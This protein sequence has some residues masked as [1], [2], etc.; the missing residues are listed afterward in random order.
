MTL[1]LDLPV[2]T[3]ERLKQRARERGQDV[4]QYVRDLVEN[5]ITPPWNE[6]VK[7]IHDEFERIGMTQEE[8]D[9]LADEL[10]RE[11]RAENLSVRG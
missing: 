9:D 4:Q 6:I 2:A 3:E 11:V 10:I 8:L 7:P 1:I 5:D